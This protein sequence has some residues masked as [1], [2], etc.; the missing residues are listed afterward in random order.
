MHYFELFRSKR[1]M[2]LLYFSYRIIL[3]LIYVGFSNP[4]FS[5]MGLTKNII[6]SKLLIS[7]LLTLFFSFIIPKGNGKVSR[8]ILQLHYIIMI[9]PLL[10]VYGLAGLSTEFTMMVTSCFTL[11]IIAIYILPDVKPLRISNSKNLIRV[12][13]LTITI[14]TYA[15]MLLTQPIN[16]SAFNFNE[17]YSIRAEQHI[18]SFMKYLLVWQYRVINPVLLVTSLINK[19]KIRFLAVAFLQLILY[20]IYPHKE[21]IFSIGLIIISVFFSRE[22]INFDKAITVLLIFIS[23]LGAFLYN[24]FGYLVL[25]G[26]FPVRFLNLPA[27]IKFEHFDFFSKNAKLY[28]SEGII[29]K[30]LNIGSPYDVSAGVLVNPRGGN[31]NTG[32]IAYAYDNFGFLGMILITVVF[33]IVLKLIDSLAINKHKNLIFALYIYPMIVLNDGDLLTMLLTGG[34]WLLFLILFLYKNRTIAEE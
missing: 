13:V 15:Y 24:A 18:N 17:I 30:L 34:L 29:G 10:S 23:S 32:F 22:E 1:W 8:M 12:L 9:I 5:Y 3:D 25:F 21:V 31:S 16:L 7:Y 20:L 14:V 11:Q 33:I 26:L 4:I 19:Q 27:K 28:Y 6:I 2:P